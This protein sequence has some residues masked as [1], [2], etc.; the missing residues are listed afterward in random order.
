M[1][2]VVGIDLGTT[3]S[4][5]AIVNNYGK[6][7]I[8]TNREGERITP[9]V[10]L[11]D[12]RDVIVGSIAKRSAV[13][14]PFNVVQFVKRQIGD[15]SWK[16][17]TDNKEDFTPEEISA[18]ILRRLKEDAETLLNEEI[19]DAVITVPA[20]FD[21]AQRKATQDAGRIAGLNVLRIINEP[22]AAALAYG[23]NKMN[24]EQNLLVYDLGGGTFDVTIMNLSPQGLRVLSTGGAKNLGG[25]DWD[26]AVMAYL[27]E[28]FKKQGGIDLLED[29]MLEQDLRDKAE[30]AKKTL[31]VRDRT[32]VFLSANGLNTS[33][34]LTRTKF[35]EITAHLLTRTKK[36]MEFVLEDAQLNWKDIDKVLLVGGSTR[37]RQVPA[38]I[39]RVTGKKPS[40]DVNPDE[41]VAMGAA[42][43][44]A[45]LQ[46][47]QGKAD[48]QLTSVFPVVNVQ[49]VNSHSM[50]V[51]ALDEEGREFNSIVLRKDTPIPCKVSGHYTT[52]VDHQTRL[53]L[54]ITEGEYSELDY[55]KI[56]GEG[57]I[58]L[59]EY[60][61]GAPLEV[62][63]EYDSDGIIHI[64]VI[65]S[66]QGAR[67]G[68]LQIQRTSNLTESEVIEK[69]RRVAQLAIG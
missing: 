28:E 35:D 29:P 19:E 49:D 53:H 8:L 1:G 18:M 26:N 15:K 21:D 36:I 64:T 31:S 55:V 17:Q 47:K 69:R 50:G 22:T 66:T 68:E 62:I 20:Y 32:N 60:P 14:S 54:Q 16:F 57:M 48:P 42:I 5:I 56:V 43:Q 30:I 9:S 41:V 33:V 46:V 39:E 27:N 2:R 10:V 45:I 63:F 25:F 61:K 52:T 4:A 38:M 3:Y 40:L 58:D 13:A 44:G 7:E 11:F 65:D 37:M 67:L 51:V 12:N 23:L 59:P 34:T 24:Q 6:P